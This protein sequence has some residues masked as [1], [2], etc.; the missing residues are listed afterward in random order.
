VLHC[1]LQWNAT[2]SPEEAGLGESRRVPAITWVSNPAVEGACIVT[3][4]VGRMR[5]EVVLEHRRS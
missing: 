3:V 4:R 2:Q 1:G 5:G